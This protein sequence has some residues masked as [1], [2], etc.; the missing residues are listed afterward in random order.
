MIKSN[1][2]IRESDNIKISEY[3][4]LKYNEIDDAFIYEDI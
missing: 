1:K 4:S 2:E 3:Y